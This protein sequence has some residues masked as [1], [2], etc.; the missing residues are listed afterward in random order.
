[1]NI[2]IYIY[3]YA[4]PCGTLP[5]SRRGRTDRD[6][7]PSSF[8][9]APSDNMDCFLLLS[10]SLF[11]K[12]PVKDIEICTPGLHNKNPIHVTRFSPRVGLPRII[13]IIGT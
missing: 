3:I 8:F 4:G 1:M 11:S 6:P 9:E 13:D 7:E 12:R 5:R 10:G 2:Y